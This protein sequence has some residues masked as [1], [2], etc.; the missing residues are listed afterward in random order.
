[1][2]FK[3]IELETQRSDAI[4]GGAGASGPAPELQH[5]QPGPRFFVNKSRIRDIRRIYM[6]NLG[7][8]TDI[9]PAVSSFRYIPGTGISHLDFT[10]SGISWGNPLP[11]QVYPGDTFFYYPISQG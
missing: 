2:G 6:L 1:M 10:S 3:E 9:P 4:M 11:V 5:Q 8:H 7:F